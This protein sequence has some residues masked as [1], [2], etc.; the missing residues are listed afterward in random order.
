MEKRIITLCCRKII[1]VN[2]TRPW[3]KLVFEDSYLE[4]KM[5][6]QLYNPEKKYQTFGE[7]L[8]YAPGAQQLHFL[9]SGA[10]TGYVAQ[11]NETVPDIVNNL[12]RHFLRFTQ[13]QFEI[14][15]SHL[16][17]K[18]RHQVAINFY[19]GPLAWHATIG[20]QLLVSE[21]QQGDAAGEMLTNLFSLQPYVNIHSL[22]QAL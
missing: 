5:Q 16:L 11:L 22:Q 20:N 4:F 18:T 15:N 12:G 19:T 10:V 8:Q 7:L 2:A 1:D 17:D 6:S 21:M 13:F 14:I 3:D 9:V